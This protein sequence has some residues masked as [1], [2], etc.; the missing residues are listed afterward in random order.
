MKWYTSSWERPSNS[1]ARVLVPPSVSKRYSF[2]TGTH[3]S[4]RRLRVSSSPR[5]VSSF[6]SFSSASRSACHSSC[7]AILCS[8][9]NV[10]PPVWVGGEY[11]VCK[12]AN[13]RRSPWRTVVFVVAAEP[14]HG[15]IAFVAALRSAVED[16]V[17]AYEEL[18]TAGVGGVAVVD[19]V[20]LARERA[21]AVSFGQ[22][23][24]DVRT[25]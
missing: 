25:A 11:I 12:I 24:V 20:A 17:V 16:R 5:R 8:L 6:S 21:D 1:S 15:L 7:V 22:I 4:S 14:G 10:S 13:D 23:A 18:R 3:G 19:G 9:I 2:W